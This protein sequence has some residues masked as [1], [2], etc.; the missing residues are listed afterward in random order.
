ML[1]LSCKP[2]VPQNRDPKTS[3]HTSNP[4]PSPKGTRLLLC[5]PII[6]LLPAAFFN[7]QWWP[8]PS[9]KSNTWRHIKHLLRCVKSAS[10]KTR[11]SC[12]R[13]AIGSQVDPH[14]LDN[15]AD[16]SAQETCIH[17]FAFAYW[18]RMRTC[19]LPNRPSAKRRIVTHTKCTMQQQVQLLCRDQTEQ[20][21]RMH[22]A[23]C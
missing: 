4:N 16:T 10:K 11:W 7:M 5:C 3:S 1:P 9:C 17:P 23:G 15:R 21:K 19:A 20:A 13:V 2:C 12:K 8:Q 18:L 14:S 6:R 22:P